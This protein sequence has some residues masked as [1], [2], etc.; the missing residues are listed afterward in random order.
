M[1]MSGEL[2]KGVQLLLGEEPYVVLHVTFQSP[3]ARGADTM[4]KAKLRNLLNESVHDKTFRGGEKL[5]QPNCELRDV[6]YLYSDGEAWHFMDAATFDQFAM[7]REELGD[8]ILYLKE[9]IEGIRALH[10]NERVVGLE[11]PNTVEL[12]VE[13]CEPSLKG[14]TAKAQTKAARLET[15]LE[16]QVPPYM[17]PG[18]TVRVDTRD[19]SFVRRV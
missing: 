17:E 3:K 8:Q 10:F 1:I 7:N 5:E 14:A 12:V 6:T 18:E 15:G 19:G 4:V 9:G 11:L 13:M 2:K 16:I